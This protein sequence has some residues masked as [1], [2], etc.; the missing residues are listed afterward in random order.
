[1]RRFEHRARHLVPARPGSVAERPMM[2]VGHGGTAPGST[3][4]D[5]G[6]Q[7][8]ATLSSGRAMT[9]YGRWICKFEEA[10]RHLVFHLAKLAGQPRALQPR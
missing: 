2:F 4:H 7:V 8:D 3:R 9:Y 6:V 10:R 5:R 1:M